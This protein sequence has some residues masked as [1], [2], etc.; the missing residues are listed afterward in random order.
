MS[1]AEPE[2]F[3]LMNR[4]PDLP[5]F[6]KRF[7]FHGPSGVLVFRI[8]IQDYTHDGLVIVGGP[9]ITGSETY[10]TGHVEDC[11]GKPLTAFVT[12]SQYM[13]LSNG[14]LP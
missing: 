10:E 6:G 11:T 3:I 14:P 4:A 8:D 2:P 1:D 7:T 12:E 9:V 5:H 13:R